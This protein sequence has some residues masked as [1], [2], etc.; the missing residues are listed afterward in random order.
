MILGALIAF[1]LWA[2]TALTLSVIH[3]APFVGRDV[4]PAALWTSVGAL[5]GH[6]VS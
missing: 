6:F 5:I 4:F 2:F 1:V 3:D